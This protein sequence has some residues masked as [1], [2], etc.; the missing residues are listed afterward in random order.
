MG[1]RIASRRLHATCEGP[2]RSAISDTQEDT[3][4]GSAT[5]NTTPYHLFK[6]VECFVPNKEL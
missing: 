3:Q 6:K 2:D 5:I 4:C 1:K